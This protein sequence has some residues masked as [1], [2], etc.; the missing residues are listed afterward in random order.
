[1][2][3]LS[4]DPSRTVPRVSAVSSRE[5]SQ[6]PYCS[7]FHSAL[8]APGLAA[9]REETYAL[10]SCSA[11]SGLSFAT[12]AALGDVAALAVDTVSQAAN[13]AASSQG[14][15]HASARRM[16]SA[17]TSPT[18]LSRASAPAAAITTMHW[19][20]RSCCM[21]A[22]KI[23]NREA[24]HWS[25]RPRLMTAYSTSEPRTTSESALWPLAGTVTLPTWLRWPLKG[26][27]C[28]DT[29]SGLTAAKL[30][31]R[32]TPQRCRTVPSGR[33]A[34]TQVWPERLRVQPEPAQM[35]WYSGHDGPATR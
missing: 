22:V 11:R 19:M 34:A 8:S 26:P 35:C 6:P 23:S 30:R 33:A 17:A 9:L 15:S 2:A 16:S 18:S 24:S 12:R 27:A 5:C 10:Y 25:P 29:P 28:A 21:T 32:L 3:R 7:S 1:M 14:Y 31:A 13:S 20:F 4:S